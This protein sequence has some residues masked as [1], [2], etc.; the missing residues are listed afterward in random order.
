MTS[1]LRKLKLARRNTVYSGLT[2]AFLQIAGTTPRA[3]SDAA[4]AALIVKLD[5]ARV[6]TFFEEGRPSD[7][8]TTRDPGA[9]RRYARGGGRESQTAKILHTVATTL[10]QL[11]TREGLKACRAGRELFTYNITVEHLR[12]LH[13]D[14]AVIGS[15]TSI[16]NGDAPDSHSEG[17]K[18][19]VNDSDRTMA[20]G[21][22]GGQAP[23]QFHNPVLK[24]DVVVS[25]T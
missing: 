3:L 9:T 18:W 1:D 24:S 16:L 7:V 4:Q 15:T 6:Q 20:P 5:G 12:S 2:P 8:M 14:P 17:W 11:L 19:L 10:G 25:L 13:S 21:V 22:S 23:F